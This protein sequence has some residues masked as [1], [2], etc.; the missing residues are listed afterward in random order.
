MANGQVC[1][2]DHDCTQR[3]EVLGLPLPVYLPGKSL[4]GL[5]VQ[6]PPGISVKQ[7]SLPGKGGFWG[8]E[9]YGK[10]EKGPWACDL[11]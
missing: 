7:S 5:S 4:P 9:F 3:H 11:L 6:I 10:V 8:V 1:R 2:A